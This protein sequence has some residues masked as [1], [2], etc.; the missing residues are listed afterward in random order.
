MIWC[1]A[2]S[3]QFIAAAAAVFWL[4]V[5]VGITAAMSSS[6]YGRVLVVG[7]GIT[8]AVT[9]SLIKQIIG[10]ENVTVWDKARGAGGRMSTSRSPGNSKCQVDLGAQYVSA[11]PSNQCLH[12]EIYSELLSANVIH[13]LDTK[14]IHGFRFGDEGSKHYCLPDGMSSLVKYFFKS[15]EAEVEFN[16]RIVDITS[17]STCWRVE[18]DKGVKGEYEA[19]ILTMPVPQ[20]LELSGDISRIIKQDQTLYNNLQSVKYSTRFA[21]GLFFDLAVD[22]GVTWTSNYISNH[23]IFRFVAVD[24]LKRGDVA[25]PTSVIAHT[26]VPFG[27]KN[28]DSSPGELQDQL[29]LSLQE[30]FPSWPQPASVKCLK[31]KYSQVS[32]SY[33]GSPGCLVISEKPLLI[34]A[35]DGFAPS[36][37]L[38]GCINSSL[39]T[40]K[41]FAP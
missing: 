41:L 39:S 26:S 7:G 35:G 31:W 37:N 1:L 25:G 8:A 21:I 29:L 13:P 11:T 24:N 32:R 6:S 9:T 14:G 30:M 2:A 40:A 18:T 12:Q 23:P 17:Q 36:S 38:D 15:A 16:K 20:I 3:I 33:P 28:I 34:L 27:V 22:L 19:V 10:K 5:G 4:V